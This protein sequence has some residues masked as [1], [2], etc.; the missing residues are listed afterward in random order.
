MPVLNQEKI[1]MP[2]VAYRIGATGDQV[3]YWLKLLGA[4]T[5]REGRVSFV[6][7]G[8]LDRLT[9][10]AALVHEGIPPKDA[11]DRVSSGVGETVVCPEP[12]PADVAAPTLPSLAV[13]EDR[14][15][16]LEKALLAMAEEMRRSREENAAHLLKMERQMAFLSLENKALRDEVVR[17]ATSTRALLAPPEQT[18][19]LVPWR[20]AP[21]PDPLEGKPW[22]VKAWVRL[23]DPARQR[24]WDS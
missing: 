6:D 22:Y 5:S 4:T 19:Q 16:S 7:Q 20:P 15:A 18:R 11:A 8:T 12:V 13:T 21:A 10:M 2:D 24:R 9:M 17:Q 14:L 1:A 23:V 3:R